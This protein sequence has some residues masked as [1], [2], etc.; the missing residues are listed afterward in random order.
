MSGELNGV[1]A[2]IQR[3]FPSAYY[4]HC[5]AHRMSLSASQSANKILQVAKFFV[6]VDTLINF[7][8]TSPK[9]TRNLGHNLPKPGDTRW[10][11]RDS[12]IAVIHSS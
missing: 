5:V 1:Q 12:A 2:Q 10:C 8:R 11:S 3:K 9:R 7:F 4:N 6:T